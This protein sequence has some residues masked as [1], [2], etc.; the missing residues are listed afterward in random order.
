MR[1]YVKVKQVSE[2]LTGTPLAVRQ[3]S[4]RFQSLLKECNETV[5]QIITKSEL[6]EEQKQ[7]EK[8]LSK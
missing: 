5:E 8:T 6:N 7:L 1:N 3:T 2:R 4:K